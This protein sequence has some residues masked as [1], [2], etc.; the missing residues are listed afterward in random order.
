LLPLYMALLPK[1]YFLSLNMKNKVKLILI[2]TGFTLAII[3]LI[4]FNKAFSGNSFSNDLTEV[5]KGTFEITVTA[6]GE[7]MP[8]KS[9]DIIGPTLPINNNRR[10]GRRNRIRASNLEI[11]DIVPE[12][13]IVNKGDYV[14]QLDRTTYD[15]TLKDQVER[16]DEM[17]RD[18]HMKLLDT[19][20][21]LTNLR[22]GLK[23]QVFTVEEA[24][25]ALK[26]S[27]YEPPAT[28]RKAKIEL[29]KT[30]RKLNQQKKLYKLRAAQQLKELNN[31]K[32][33]IE[34]Q[35]RTISDLENYLAGFTVTAPASG[36][37]IYKRNRNG[38][39][40]QVGSSINPW[41]MVIATLPDLSSMISR[42]Y[43]SEVY[44]SKVKIGQ[45]VN[46]KIDAFSDK[47]YSG[48]VINIGKIGEQLPNSDTKMFEV[49]CRIDGYDL[50]LR[51]AMTTGNGIT[52]KSIDNAVYIPL[53]CV[54]TD[55]DG[56][57]F[58][59]TMEKTK[60]EVILGEANEKNIII[61]KGLEPG[62][63]I[64][65][66]TPENSEEFRLQGLITPDNTA[67]T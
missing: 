13:T 39:K 29:D 9:T 16:L 34:G 56:I 8:E 67:G 25:I 15:N 28:I 42:T 53:E 57:T 33:E 26:I 21:V 7:L 66:N 58:V 30:K 17:Q 3:A 61:K 18:L 62:T 31:L 20:V 37:V 22:D 50:T 49:S 45:K 55:S 60:Q 64:Y 5:I 63:L 32:T 43:I 6:A 38:T 36:M 2:I 35:N 59:Y 12:G 52:I 47:S 40:R 65:L 51:P 14:A 19:A 41:D 46:I 23:N 44:I 27:A 11:Q 1:F 10:R 54:H 4:F 48:E 24:E